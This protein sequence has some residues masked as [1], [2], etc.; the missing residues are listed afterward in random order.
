MLQEVPPDAESGERRSWRG[1]GSGSRGVN[2]LASLTVELLLELL[3]TGY[4]SAY[5][6]PLPIQSQFFPLGSK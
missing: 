6:N 2:E 4:A 1:L 5:Q 3:D